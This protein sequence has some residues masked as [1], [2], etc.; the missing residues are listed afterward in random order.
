MKAIEAQ[1]RAK[2]KLGGED[3]FTTVVADVNTNNTV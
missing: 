2:L 3:A 1:K